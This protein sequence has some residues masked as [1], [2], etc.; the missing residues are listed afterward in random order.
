MPHWPYLP[1]EGRDELED[2]KRGA[3]VAGIAGLRAGAGTTF[4]VTVFFTVV[5]TFTGSL[6]I[7]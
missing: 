1:E 3:G 7:S 5:V 2:F 4:G 6:G